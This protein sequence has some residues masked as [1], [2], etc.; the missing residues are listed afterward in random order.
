[1]ATAKDAQAVKSLNKS[2][3]R[4]RFVF[5][6]FSQR[7]EEIEIDVFRSLHPL[8]S[9]PS[10]GSSFF[11]DC[12]VEWREL[13][14]AEDFISLYEEI[15]PLVQTLPQII[16]HKELILSKL[17][18]RLQMEGRLSLEP[19]L[20]L[21]AALS[22]DLLD[23]FRQFL[24]RVADA[25][26]YLL[27]SG[28]D[29]EPEIIE[30]IFTSWSHIMMYL[31]K[32]LVRDVVHVLRVSAKLR[33]YPKDY[34]QEFMA[35]AVS[36]LLRSALTHAP[37]QFIKGTR[38]VMVEVAKKPLVHR[39]SGVSALLWYVMR[40]ASLKL[41]SRAE[42]VLQVLMDD[43]TLKIGDK[44]VEGS[45]SVLEV[46]TIAF[47]RLCEELEPTELKLLFRCLF[48][49]IKNAVSSG[50]SLH[51]CRLLSLL[52]STVHKD[53]I[54]KLC[55]YQLML[56]VV[57]VIMQKFVLTSG[58]VNSE[59]HFS[60]VVDKLL[61]LMLC[62]VDG[63]CLADNGSVMSHVSV[64]WTP[65]F[66][67]RNSS[68]LT[69]IEQLLLTFIKQLLLKDPRIVHAFRRNILSVLSDLIETSE[70]EVILLLL[71]FSERI[72]VHVQSSD[73]L[74]GTSS[75]QV[76]RI[77]TY[78]QNAIG[79]WIGV[80]NQI[81]HGDPSSIQ[82]PE[83]KLAL[84]WGIISCYPFMSQANSS[85]LL[86]FVEALDQL[87]A[88]EYDNIAGFHKHAWQSL[89]GAALSSFNKLSSGNLNREVV[90]TFLQ[91]AARYKSSSQ[92]LSAVADFLDSMDRRTF[93]EDTSSVVLHPEL[94]AT[95]AKE[96][97]AFF[98]ENLCHSDKVTRV[99]TLRILCHYQL[100]RC[101][102]SSKDEP[103]EIGMKT[104]VSES[105]LENNQGCNVL[106]LLLSIEDTPLSITTSRKVI[107]LISR[108]QMGLSGARI[109]GIY[110]P[111]VLYGVIGIFHNRFSYLWDPALDCIAILISKYFDM[112]WDIFV[113][114]LEQCESNFLG[115]H[116]QSDR[117]RS[118]STSKSSVLTLLIQSLQKVPTVAE[119]RSEQ[120][121]PLFLKFIGY[122]VN[123]VVSVGSFNTQAVKGK[124]WKN[125]LKEWLTLLKLM[126]NPGS[127]YRS[128]FLKEVLQYRLLEENDAEIQMKVLDCLLN[129][130][131]DFLVPYD[132]HLK[133]LISSKSLREELTT[134]SLSKESNLIEQRHRSYLLPLVTRVL[135][136]KVRKL[137]TLA[138]RKHKS[139]HHRKAVLGFVAQLDVD[140]L[141]LF[142]ALLIKP[143]LSI[144]QG[145]DGN[146]G[147]SKWFWSSPEWSMDEFD[148]FMF[149]KYFTMDNIMALSWKKRYAFLH[150]IEDILGVFDE[151][152]V[153]PYLDLLMGCVVHILWSCTSI[154][155]SD[156]SV[157][158]T[159]SSLLTM[160][161]K[162]GGAENQ[163]TTSTAIK[164]FKELR[165]LCLK[166]IS[167]VLKKYDHELGCEFW[168]HFFKSVKPLIDGFK[169][170]G[171]SSEKPSSLFS[172]FLTMSGDYKL[173]SLL[174]REKSL[175]PDI[176]SILTVP[177]ASEAILSCVLKF[178]ENLLNLD[179]ELNGE[180]NAAK[181]ILL[182][183]LDSLISGLHCLFKFNNAARRDTLEALYAIGKL[184]KCPG[185][186]ELC[187]FRLLS[188]YIKDPSAASKFV[189]I[190]LP[191]LTKEVQSSDACVEALHVIQ[192][193]I[194]VLGSES[195]T[196]ILNA[197]SPL[198]IS[199]S[200]DLRM[201]VCDLLDA[202]AGTDSSLIAVAKLV[203]ELNST[204]AME[205]GGLDYDS[206]IG[207][208]E[209]ISKDF[210]YTVKEKHALLIL[211][212]AVHDMS[213]EEL[214]LRQSA[215]RLLLSYI[216]FSAELLE[217]EMK[218]DDRSWSES[219]IHQ[220]INKFFFKH[221]GDAMNR[222][223]STQKVWIELL[224]EMVLKLSMVPSLKSLK[225]LCSE[226]AEQDFFNNILHLQ[227][228]RR[229]RALLRFRNFVISGSLSE[230]ITIKVFV[231][232][233][234]N[235]L[236][237]LQRG[238]SENVRSACLEALASISGNMEWKSYYTFLMRCFREM[239]QKSD[240]QKVLL[241][242]IC[243]VLDR[244]HFIE[245]YS[246]QEAE[247]SIVEES[248]TVLR[249]CSSS[250]EVTEIQERLLRNVLPKI[251]KL[252]ASDSDNVNVHISIVALK[253]LKLLPGD[254]MELQLPSIVHRISNFLKNRLESIRDEARDALAACLKE[255][256]LEYLQ[257]I[258][259]VL[260]ATLKRGYELHVL[261]YTLNF[262]LSKFLV[263]PVAGKLDYCLEDLL[264]V[265]EN[266][267]LGDVSEEKE[268]DKIASKMKE[269]RKLKSFETLKL[270]AQNITFKTHAVKLLSRVAIRLQRHLTPKVKLKLES[271]LNNIA[272]GI[273]C[274]PSVNQPDLFIFLYDL[275]EDGITYEA[276]TNTSSSV[277][278]TNKKL[279]DGLIGKITTSG[280]LID[281]SSQCSHLVKVFALG[282]L[283]SCMKKTKLH[284]IDEHV[285][286]M[287][288]PFIR[289][290]TDC[291]TSKYEDI[292][293]GALR[294]L[295]P[296]VGLPL[297]ALKSEGDKIKTSLLV[298]AQGSM[299]GS[300]LMQSCLSY[301]HSSGRETVLEMLHAIVMKFPKP[302][303]DE[304]SLEIFVRLVF[305]LAN[306]NDNKVR[307]MTGAA[308]KLLIGHVSPHS[309]HS[310]I[311]Y[312]FSWYLGG[313]QDLWSAAAQVL[314]FLVEVM[315]EDFQKHINRVL[316]V[317]TIIFQSAL[318]DLKNGS[319]DVSNEATWKG[320]YYSLIMLE[321][322]LHQFHD[323][324]LGRDLEN[325][326]GIICELLVHP[327]M[328]LRNVLNRLVAR[329][330][331]LVSEAD[332]ANHDKSLG[333]F[334]LMRPSRLFLVAVSL[335]CQLKAPLIDD[336]ASTLITQNLTFVICA[337]QS[338]LG[339]N[340][341][342][343]DQSIWS[344]VEH[345]E[346]VRFVEAFQ[347][348]D[349]G[350]GGTMYASL[351]SG[352]NS[353]NAEENSDHRQPLLVSSL[354]KRMGK[355]ALKMEAV[356]MKIVFNVFK[357][358]S[359]KIIDPEKLSSQPSD[360]QGYA[361]PLLLPLYKVCEG[362]AGKVIPDDVKQLAEEALET[363]RDTLG[364]NSFVQVYSHIRKSL[365]AK[366][367][368]RK[369]GEKVMAVVNPERNAQ[370][371][372]RIS[373]KNQA[374]KRRR[375]TTMKMRKWVH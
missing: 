286:S 22:R 305:C 220:I 227:K 68:S 212:H 167:L 267:I 251:Q 87:L 9:E 338:F 347:L 284:K 12:L 321:K 289:L 310:I 43:S 69:F 176:F 199:V 304:H 313:K 158:E 325:I 203:R 221:M 156:L 115:S 244:L 324:C 349:S 302:V 6:T 162:G 223:A 49:E 262:V 281:C 202:L 21:I 292:I 3:G 191:L 136:P 218:S 209:K 89:I 237:E 111:S 320:A 346:Q 33:Y 155:D 273:E 359:P 365:K 66:E 351:T 343:G 130:K 119:S 253:L 42:Y 268:V 350:K 96:S 103:A 344:A 280:R 93:Q 358:I 303:L 160:H 26:A 59:D 296:L 99:S 23:E 44:F 328:W 57:D 145:L 74:D 326:W 50:G 5:Q 329:Y 125:V 40:G 17:L 37:D 178:V 95:K 197:V 55:D 332:G 368:K 112:T 11:R 370:R 261:G 32:Y 375:V 171:A 25:L 366:R 124:E 134:W 144:S 345:H 2:P 166:V 270:I 8:K 341:L 314:G 97:L 315:K 173:I 141:R 312:S 229:A 113:Q 214:I 147:M 29:R 219:C 300:P 294:C 336:A 62:I 64:Q 104:E 107:L 56:E 72:E 39:K 248:K 207:A 307:S 164:Q 252:M 46:V 257:F 184:V 146:H 102:H 142:F 118:A 148:S 52:I 149:L 30:Q 77:C 159:H 363:I 20:R 258:V 319:L 249:C 92:I 7:V 108:I 122:N 297:P 243:L 181:R 132:Q 226:D 330:F 269:T 18:S 210:F 271:M 35:E 193:M 131:D 168:D 41:H 14:T 27:K 135:I 79:Y 116:D 211:S 316:P 90:S 299:N 157:V 317:M 373:A 279:G 356:Q 133:N 201:T 165:S 282:L 335:C 247:G 172:C 225:V 182:P 63:L 361:Y 285:L 372:R 78:L 81:V 161:E 163:I 4:R 101:E 306:D 34:V 86:D 121:V 245:T 98:A 357:A 283:H 71:I 76:S 128:Q 250:A 272:A 362:Y 236:F 152:H 241:R 277:S 256:G 322:I 293:S 291:L 354:L 139:V 109:A 213:S 140:E 73:L 28:A 88:I 352:D 187:I 348:L 75:Q 204:S 143:L 287:L 80:I 94:K 200:L 38:K 100:L 110:M 15:M 65:V 170:E 234:F 274:N 194:P 189:D 84:L 263:N 233:F 31:Q 120:I 60:E 216:E 192:Q 353:Q 364:M 36:F 106:Q 222:E 208:Y 290:L 232:L 265:V 179:S 174:D 70:E 91:V 82:R 264:S 333:T 175:V 10:E 198:L 48:E 311:E 246:G 16:L 323:L 339:P 177:T 238:K 58:I 51:L 337:L 19:I 295:A 255:L 54:Q 275:I 105:C 180:D 1:M 308:I 47:Q 360:F 185:E 334:F 53:Y 230:V 224:R 169:Q 331:A 114:Y 151:S 126:R 138:S 278:N 367:D 318:D 67:L 195:R 240:M 342:V 83:T 117:S 127:F 61:Q 85:L 288:D 150:V 242:L 259:K 327:H 137:K 355:I 190:M 340:K 298:I 301:K 254:V 205:M 196:E 183:N 266:D 276:H 206:I 374:N 129:W 188:K 260:R 186:R 153:K 371:K 228:H 45:Q 24:Q 215:F 231:P 235:M 154:I 13:N 309:L 123:D 239:S 369:Q 217:R